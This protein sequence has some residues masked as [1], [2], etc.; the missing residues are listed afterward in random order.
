MIAIVAKIADSSPAS[1]MEDTRTLVDTLVRDY[2]TLV[3]PGHFFQ[4]PTHIRISFGGEPEMVKEALARL[5]RAL[6]VLP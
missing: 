3:V 5:A 2:D 4:S 6:E 1:R